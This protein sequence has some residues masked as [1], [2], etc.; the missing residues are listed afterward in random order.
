HTNL[1]SAWRWALSLRCEGSRNVLSALRKAM[2]VDFKDKDKHES[3]G[4]YLF[5]GGVPDQDVP[6]LSAYVAEACG[7]CA[8]QLHV[9]L[10]Y[11]G[12]P[13]MNT[14]PPACY[15]S[16]TDT[17]TAYK[18]VTRAARGRFHWFGE[19]GIYES[20][21]INAIVSE[22]E[23]AL[24]YSQ[25][26]AFLVA[27]LKNQSRKEL[28]SMAEGGDKSKMLKQSQPKKFCP[29]KATAPSVTRMV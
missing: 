8:L 4:I 29:P 6:T 5:T 19:A 21:D 9:C 20:D 17:A 11:V 3:Q 13:Q 26:C 16:R 27:S 23:R 28:E 22:M 2:E 1:Q 7:G 18:E 15:A 14:T 12:E 10:F 25:K 24:N